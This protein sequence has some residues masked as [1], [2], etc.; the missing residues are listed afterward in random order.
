M[1]KCTKLVRSRGLN[2]TATA[3]LRT[4]NCELLV[5][6]CDCTDCPVIWP[7]R[8]FA[9]PDTCPIFSPRVRLS[10]K[11]CMLSQ[12]DA[13]VIMAM[14][15]SV[16]Q[17]HSANQHDDAM[18]AHDSLQDFQSIDDLSSAGINV[19]EIELM[20]SQIGLHCVEDVV[21]TPLKRLT[22]TKVIFFCLFHFRACLLHQHA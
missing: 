3:R 13:Q 5:R 15:A 1:K 10:R 4:A 18:E 12:T 22:E 21:H 9:R 20:K 11:Y 8:S 16:R 17:Q 7:V 19:R 6:I 2:F 14:S